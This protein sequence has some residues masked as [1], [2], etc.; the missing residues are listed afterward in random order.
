MVATFQFSK[1]AQRLCALRVPKTLESEIREKARK[2]G[3]QILSPCKVPV[4]TETLHLEEQ[5]IHRLAKE[6]S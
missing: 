2:I 3:E 6:E 4:S 5:E 1:A